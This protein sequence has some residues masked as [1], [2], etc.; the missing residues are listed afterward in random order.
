MVLCWSLHLDR[1]AAKRVL[2]TL[3]CLVLVPFHTPLHRS[4]SSH[5]S[6]TAP[7]AVAAIPPATLSAAPVL[8]PFLHSLTIEG[9]LTLASDEAGPA[10]QAA[11]ATATATVSAGSGSGGSGGG[12]GSDG[13]RAVRLAPHPTVPKLVARP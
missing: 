12:S 13:G 9:L 5:A 4:F 11:A 6:P 8:A 10:L 3:G 2:L 1:N 7:Y